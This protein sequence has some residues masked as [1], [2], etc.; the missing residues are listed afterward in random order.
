MREIA[1][2]GSTGSIGSQALEVI[3][4]YPER[5]RTA[6]LTAYSKADALFE[7]VRRHRPRM[8]GLVVPPKEIPGDVRFCQ[9]VFGEECLLAAATLPEAEDVL[10]SVV[11]FAGLTAV[12]SA[13]SAGKRVL[14][15]NKEALVAGGALVTEAARAAGQVLL[16]VDSEHSAVF[17]CLRGADGNVP[18]RVIL[19]AS[20]GPFRTWEPQAIETATVSQALRH[21]NWAMGRKI[22]VDSA[23]MLNKALEV[24]EAYWLFGLSPDQIHVTIHPESIIH[25][26]VE[27][28]DGAV[29]AQMGYPDMR[30]PILYAMS[31]PERLALPGDPLDFAK[32]GRLTFETPDHA[33]FPGLALAYDALHAGGTAGAVLNAANEI[34]VEAFLAQR[35]PF[36]RIY[37]T[38]RDVLQRMPI[39]PVNTLNDVRHADAEARRMARLLLS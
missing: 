22:T 31:Y 34:A 5:F 7:Q 23:S 27:F 25:S 18:V 12:L 36:G 26:M 17:Q 13:F 39:G 11:G 16:P 38:T 28:A 4:M 8:A 35:I 2:L 33:K 29:L 14:L 30:L 24:I 15:A 10:V 19:T 1:I 21:P 32:V 20:G 6:A 9:W 37:R 3:G